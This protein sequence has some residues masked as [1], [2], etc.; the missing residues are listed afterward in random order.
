MNI[1]LTGGT[2]F[3]GSNFINYAM[4]LGDN[5]IALK[6]ESSTPRVKLNSEPKWVKKNF[7]DLELNDFEDIDVFVHMSAHSVIPPVD[8]L[9]NCLK[10]N[11]FEPK[12][13]VEKAMKA[14]IKKFI[15]IG[16]CFEYGNSA[17][18]FDKIPINAEL[19]PL[20]NYSKSKV[21]FLYKMQELFSE[22][23]FYSVNYLR[24]FHIYGQGENELRFW[25]SLKKAA[26]NNLD[27]ELTLGEQ[28]RDFMNIEEAIKKI[29][30]KILELDNFYGFEIKNMGTGEIK[31]LKEFA[32]A[33]WSKFNAKGVLK[34]GVIP[35]RHNEIMRL[36]PQL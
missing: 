21:D 27:F 5:V 1:F 29:Y 35:Y 4:Q 25:P 9:E 14:G 33:E 34:F 28:Y 6:R 13:I 15:F 19:K 30:Q 12:L 31:T 32:Q 17:D 11:S 24:L 23:E 22:K 8:T 3:I 26:L 7:L 20:D 2:G 10:F 36:I 18:K 16:S